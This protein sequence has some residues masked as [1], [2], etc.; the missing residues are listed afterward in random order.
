M[1]KEIDPKGNAKETKYDA[2][3]NVI[4]EVHPYKTI[5]NV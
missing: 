1:I 4:E 2:L 3:G 5:V